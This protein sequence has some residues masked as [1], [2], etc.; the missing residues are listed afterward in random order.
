M[1][2]NRTIGKPAKRDSPTWQELPEKQVVERV[3]RFVGELRR[4]K[5]YH[6]SGS[7]RDRVVH[8]SIS[9]ST[10]LPL[11]PPPLPRKKQRSRVRSDT[12]LHTRGCSIPLGTTRDTAPSYHTHLGSSD[13]MG[14]ERCRETWSTFW[15]SMSLQHTFDGGL[16]GLLAY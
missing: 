16:F 1:E 12:P 14:I 4:W 6:R 2:A 7:D 8:S 9:A 3:D 15:P 10:L 5:S 11:P 13:C